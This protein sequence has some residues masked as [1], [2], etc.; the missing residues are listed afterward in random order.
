MENMK[1]LTHAVVLD[2]KFAPNDDIWR[3]LE[4]KLF[5][6]FTKCHISPLPSD[7]DIQHLVKK[8]SGQFIYASTVIKFIDDEDCHPKEQLDIILNLR[9]VASS[10]PYAQLDQLYIQI[11]SQQPDVRLLRDVFVLIIALD[12][13]RF[14]F[15][16]RRLRISE[17]KL[18]RKLRK[19]HSLLRIDDYDITTYHLSLSDFFRDK[20]R[21]GKYH[22]HPLRVALVRLPEHVR[23]IRE[24]VV[25]RVLE[26]LKWL[27]RFYLLL[28]LEAASNHILARDWSFMYLA[29]SMSGLLV[30][31]FGLVLSFE[32]EYE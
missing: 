23:P 17:E 4:D 30:L 14:P 24:R 13:A 31:F 6:I 27:I 12:P 8:A 16:C 22:I 25:S 32:Y 19:M 7:S 11:L 5:H 21:S 29:Y 18:R 9:P 20:N 3:Y 15:I 28:C 26:F 2:E 10:S 1:K